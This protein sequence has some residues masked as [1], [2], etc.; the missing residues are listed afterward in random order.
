MSAT[1]PEAVKKHVRTYITIFIAL[2]ILTVVTVWVSTL[3]LP[4]PAAIALAFII[5]SIKAGLVALFFMHLLG[6]RK[7]IIAI[8]ALTVFFFVVLTLL[9]QTSHVVVPIIP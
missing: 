6:E 5:A 2:A 9:P 3:D 7:I 8:L 1:S 4:G